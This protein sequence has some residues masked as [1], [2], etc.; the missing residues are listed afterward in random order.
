MANTKSAAKRA[1]QSLKRRAANRSTTSAVRSQLRKTREAIATK[2]PAAI[3]VELRA[4]TRILDRAASS[5]VLHKRNASRRVARLA[6]A[7]YAAKTP[8]KA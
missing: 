4:A 8:A 1:R 6:A 7:A 5:G 2:D 3:E